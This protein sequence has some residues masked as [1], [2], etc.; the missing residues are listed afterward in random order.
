[1]RT[2]TVRE[3]CAGSDHP[4]LV[5]RFNMADREYNRAYY[6]KHRKKL[7]Q[8]ALAYEARMSAD[9]KLKLRERQR[10][11]YRRRKTSATKE[12]LSRRRLSQARANKKR[13]SDPKERLRMNALVRARRLGNPDAHRWQSLKWQ[14][15]NP[16]GARALRARRRARIRKAQGRWSAAD[17]VEIVKRQRGRCFWCGDRLGKMHAD[18]RVPLARGGSNWPKNIVASCPPCNHRKR[19]KLPDEFLKITGE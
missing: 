6:R 16:D 13:W 9:E 3:H 15:N 17:F 14:R 5:S 1:M 2:D 12:W 11:A 8:A 4:N 19:D 10:A 18:H 7:I